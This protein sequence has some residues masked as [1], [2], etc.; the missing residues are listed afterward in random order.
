VE[1]I[2]RMNLMG[3]NIGVQAVWQ[4]LLETRTNY[5]LGSD[6]TQWHTDIPNY[7][8]VLFPG[9][10]PGV[11]ETYYANSQGEL[12]TDYVVA[13][14]ADPGVI[15]LVASGASGVSLDGQGNLVLPTAGGG[16]AL[17]AP[18]MYQVVN[19]VR[20]AVSG[21]YLVQ[22]GQ[23]GFQVGAYD[24]S[25][26]LVIDP[27]L[28]YS[29]YF[30]GSMSTTH[31]IA[32]DGSGN[33]Y[34][35][36][37][38]EGTDFPTNNAL[39]STLQGPYSA[40]V[41]KLDPSGT[42]LVYSTY[43][44]GTDTTVPNTISETGEGI[45]V[46]N[47]GNAYVT[48]WTNATDFPTIN[49]VQSSNRATG[50]SAFVSKL[51]SSG[52]SLTY[53]TYLGGSG[54][55]E[56]FGIAVDGSGSA[57]ITGFTESTDFPTNNAL[58]STNGGIVGRDG[59]VSNLSV[60]GTSLVYSTYLGGF[61][62]DH[63][64]GIAVDGS[65]AAYVTGW[66]NSTNFPTSNALQSSNR[67]TANGTAFVSKLNSAGT[68]L[69]YS[70][71][72]GGT[73]GSNPGNFGDVGQAI[74]A[75]GSGNAYVT[76]YTY[77]TDFPTAY[78]LQSS[79]HNTTS[80]DTA[81][82]S[83]LSASGSALVYSTYLGGSNEGEANGIAVDG[84]GNAYVTGYTF[85]PDFPTANAIQSIPGGSGADAF[86]SKLNPSGSTLVYSTYLGGTGADDGFAI[87]VDG[88]GN[89][90]VTGATSSTDVPTANA[91]QSNNFVSPFNGIDFVSM[92]GSMALS[93]GRPIG[94]DP[95]QGLWLPF[96]NAWY[97]PYNR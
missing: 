40:F 5:F 57:Y 81:F 16:V 73:G 54:N 65:G 74:A 3:A 35:T 22:G 47:S 77:S 75:D 53:S 50:F 64:Y 49:A 70:T 67:S 17:R 45:A 60:S 59:F 94:P 76:G 68:S 39:Q 48:G 51:S 18:E 95:Q 43:L 87:A 46:D 56:A 83:K 14:G 9:I 78:A 20:Q 82:V 63:G 25:L 26:P 80:G 12:E 86:V 24:P 28:I 2:L 66:T 41:S 79:N 42:S 27:A 32:V 44:G 19:G 37:V 7:G 13:P 6:P 72:L 61:S 8:Q 96:G 89:A 71:Y 33:A 97:S 84:T 58:Q 34:L 91:L 11:D 92:I 38:T 88:P 36:G 85:S 15:R 31:G 93:T 69:V 10:Y 62:A 1:D 52:T 30:G 90:Y 55:N 29:T 4:N 21:Q 23:V